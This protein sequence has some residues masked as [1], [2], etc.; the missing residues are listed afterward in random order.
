MPTFKLPTRLAL[1]LGTVYGAIVTLTTQLHVSP[2]A[3]KAIVF[4]GV[5]LAA[6]GIH[7]TDTAS[8]PAVEI[9]PAPDGARMTPIPPS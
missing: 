9:P 1:V 6:L 5:I 3:H 7:P 8:Q 2:E 4:A